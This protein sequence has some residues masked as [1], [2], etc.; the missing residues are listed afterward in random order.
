MFAIKLYSHG[1]SV[2]SGCAVGG[3]GGQK[4]RLP[5]DLNVYNFSGCEFADARAKRNRLGYSGHFLSNIQAFN[6]VLVQRSTP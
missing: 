2:T 6:P 4:S 3:A 1:D 5:A